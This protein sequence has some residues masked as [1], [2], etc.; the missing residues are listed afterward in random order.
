MK[1]KY[2]TINTAIAVETQG[3]KFNHK[4]LT[5]REFE[6]LAEKYGKVYTQQEFVEMFNDGLMLNPEVD[7]LR[8]VKVVLVKTSTKLTEGIYDHIRKFS[9]KVIKVA[10]GREGTFAEMYFTDNHEY[11]KSRFGMEGKGL[12]LFMEGYEK[13]K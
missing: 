7:V 13:R 4:K 2:L 12:A 9:V 8:I 10:W 11:G 1:T 5:S 6:K 3:K